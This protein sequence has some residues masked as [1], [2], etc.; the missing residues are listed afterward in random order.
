[1]ARHE[2]AHGWVWIEGHVGSGPRRTSQRVS[3]AVAKAHHSSFLF[4]TCQKCFQLYAS[5]NQVPKGYASTASQIQSANR[6][7]PADDPFCKPRAAGRT[8]N[9]RRPRASESL[10][11]RGG[12][13]GRRRVCS[14]PARPRPRRR[15]PV[16]AP[17]PKRAPPRRRWR[18][19]APLRLSGRGW[20]AGRRISTSDD[21]LVWSVPVS[22]RYRVW[23]I[24]L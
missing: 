7:R 22:L 9:D 17:A 13:L 8:F 23:P 6:F 15:H 14:P 1:M 19:A 18:S 5:A 4:L 10:A 3:S 21:R 11:L 24:W 12:G 16:R 2:C 20:K